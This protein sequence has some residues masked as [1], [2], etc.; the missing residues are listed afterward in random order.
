MLPSRGLKGSVN[1][2]GRA[3]H[4]LRTER[5]VC[6]LPRSPAR[7][8]TPVSIRSCERLLVVVHQ[9]RWGMRLLNNIPDKE[10]F[11]YLVGLHVDGVSHGPDGIAH[12]GLCRPSANH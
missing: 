11:G 3:V 2:Y 8:Y 7:A 10:R 9:W 6:V 1:E 12:A 5:S 4:P